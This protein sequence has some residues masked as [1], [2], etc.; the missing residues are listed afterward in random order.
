MNSS[1]TDLYFGLTIERRKHMSRTIIY[2][3]TSYDGGGRWKVTFWK[4]PDRSDQLTEIF[5]ACDVERVRNRIEAITGNKHFD[6]ER[7]KA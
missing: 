6:L 1:Y 4:K 5:V 7:V 2:Y 3:T